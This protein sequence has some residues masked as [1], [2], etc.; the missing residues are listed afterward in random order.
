M[1]YEHNQNDEILQVLMIVSSVG[2]TINQILGISRGSRSMMEQSGALAQ[3]YKKI[4]DL[5]LEYQKMLSEHQSIDKINQFGQYYDTEILGCYRILKS[6]IES[7]RSNIFSKGLPK[8]M[9]V[10]IIHCIQ[11]LEDGLESIMQITD[12]QNARNGYAP[13]TII[14]KNA[15]DEHELIEIPDNGNKKR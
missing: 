6:T 13:Q 8:P 1:K 4:G 12:K 5:S 15:T 14:T 7:L 11:Q 3:M 2:S 9:L 10:E